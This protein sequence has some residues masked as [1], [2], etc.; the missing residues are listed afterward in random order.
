M[1]AL[2][3][4]AYQAE[5]ETLIASTSSSYSSS[6]PAVDMGNSEKMARQKPYV[7]TKLLTAHIIHGCLLALHIVALVASI[8]GWTIPVNTLDV[9]LFQTGITAAL[10]VFFILING[11]LLSIVR[12]IAIDADIRHPPTL[13]IL[14][15]RLKSWT[16]LW[17]ATTANW[18]YWRSKLSLEES[19]LKRI[20]FY[21]GACA[22]LQISSSSLFGVDF[23]FQS[24][25]LS[26]YW[27]PNIIQGNRF[28]Y[29]DQ[30]WPLDVNISSADK[31]W[32][33]PAV[34]LAAHTM[35]AGR[36][37][38]TRYPGLQ[39]R[40]VHD[41]TNLDNGVTLLIPWSE[42]RVN[43]TE[44]NVHC[45]QINDA[46]LTTF[47]L[48][49]QSSDLSLAT[50]SP[51]NGSQRYIYQNQTDFDDGV[52]INFTMPAPPYWDR[53]ISPELNF[54]AYWGSFGE[55][56]EG[57]PTQ[58]FFQPWV[59][60]ATSA[61]LGHHQ[62]VMIIATQRNQSLI[63]DINGS[64][65]NALNFTISPDET[66]CFEDL[67]HAYV[68]AIG[69]TQT[70]T[71]LTATIDTQSRLL[72]PLTDVM[73]LEG[74]EALHDN[75][76]WDDFAWEDSKNLSGIDRQFLLAFSPTSLYND[77]SDSDSD[78][79]KP[80]IVG[81]S[82]Q[83]LS[84]LLD[85][86][87]FTPFTLTANS[88]YSNALV[89][90][91]GSL[92]RLYASY[93]WNINRLCSAFDSLQPYWEDCGTY[94]SDDLYGSADLVWEIPLSFGLSIVLWRSILSVVCC[95]I[96][97]LLGFMILGTTVDQERATPQQGQGFLNTARILNGSNI[98]EIVAKEAHTV[99][100]PRN[101]ESELLETLLT[102]RLR[103]QST[104]DVD[105]TLGGYLS[106][107]D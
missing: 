50:A 54:T 29:Y 48:P 79:S 38:D 94:L 30:L 90:F 73:Q 17:S 27:T 85:G 23:T 97:L 3:S 100:E 26:D 51:Q 69:C 41:T 66:S 77:T 44:F 55:S 92:E 104:D 13:G 60:P 45:S 11:T 68:Q 91:Q 15:L 64:V 101:L 75:H 32:F 89:E 35:F 71:N 58:V 43:A 103:Y 74:P 76:A 95:T 84:K 102:R 2:T 70:S 78:L 24:S 40:L 65:G 4:P 83:I 22:L 82:E 49:F 42:A 10:Q 9:S 20:F 1:T 88:S 14:H 5:T 57:L 56:I 80:T 93:L 46:T 47:T 36:V 81:N 105:E 8:K 16:G 53:S 52:W 6:T 7:S 25:T 86:N 99:K 96:M 67:C 18:A 37:N 98:P 61:P 87:L 31:R 33:P 19:Q 62:L 39:A 107:Y 28:G 21:I 34:L 63:T 106:V 59:F 12:D 72:D